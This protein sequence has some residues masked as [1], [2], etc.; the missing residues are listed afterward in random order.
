[1]PQRLHNAKRWR[2]LAED[3]RAIAEQMKDPECK[4]LL[5]AIAEAYAK[6]ARRALAEQPARTDNSAKET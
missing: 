5:M 1:M 3:T 6:L 4:R 2:Q